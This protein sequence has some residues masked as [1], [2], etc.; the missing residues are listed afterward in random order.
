MW[1]CSV[2][3]LII[4]V[5]ACCLRPGV[6]RAYWREQWKC[7]PCRLLMLLSKPRLS[8]DCQRC[9]WSQIVIKVKERWIWQ[10]KEDSIN[11]NAYYWVFSGDVCLP[12]PS[13]A[14]KWTVYYLHIRELIVIDSV[15]MYGLLKGRYRPKICHFFKHNFCRYVHKKCTKRITFQN[16]KALPE[17]AGVHAWCIRGIN[18]VITVCI[19]SRWTT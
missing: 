18:R 15:F 13:L 6:A 2:F 16:F 8:I 12:S 10:G 17:W 4:Q 5:H 7:L 14:V 3:G 1:N 11:K 19:N 9:C